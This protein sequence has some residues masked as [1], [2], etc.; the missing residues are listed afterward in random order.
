MKTNIIKSKINN[1]FDLL[2]FRPMNYLMLE[3]VKEYV[4]QAIIFHSLHDCSSIQYDT[5]IRLW[6]YYIWLIFN[7]IFC[8]SIAIK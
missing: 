3:G 2:F 1:I 6:N 5:A 4:R 7:Y 8:I